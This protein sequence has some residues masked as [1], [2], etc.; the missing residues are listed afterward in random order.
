[1]DRRYEHIDTEFAI[2][3]A[4]EV[5]LLQARPV[6]AIEAGGIQTVDPKSVR[7]PGAVI[8]RGSYSLL[9]AVVGRVKVI[10]DFEKLVAGEVTLG[11][12][13]I[14]VTA[15]VRHPSRLLHRGR[16]RWRTAFTPG[17]CPTCHRSR[18]QTSGTST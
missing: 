17:P 2:N 3:A 10:L 9:G 5:R 7:E 14:L 4:G 15:K 8:V 13:D 6:V 12:D 11:A 18:R 1:M 16:V